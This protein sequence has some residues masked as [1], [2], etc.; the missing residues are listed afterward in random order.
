MR[1]ELASLGPVV[2][3]VVMVHVAKQKAPLRLMDDEPD[4][5]A[6]P[7]RPEVLVPRL[8]ELVE[9]PASPAGF[10]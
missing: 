9:T 5:G 6:H 1:L 3:L 10:I 8:V 2:S 4:I 7:H